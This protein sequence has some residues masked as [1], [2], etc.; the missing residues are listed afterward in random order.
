MFLSLGAAMLLALGLALT[1]GG[2]YRLAATARS[3][4]LAAD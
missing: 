3:G 1:G 4:P 2:A